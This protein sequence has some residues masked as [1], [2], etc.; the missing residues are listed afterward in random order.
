MYEWSAGSCR[1]QVRFF[2]A[3]SSLPL[4]TN[5]RGVSI[6]KDIIMI[7]RLIGT[8]LRK[9]RILVVERR[10]DKAY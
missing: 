7:I 4:S 8:N 5:H 10:N 3:C 9:V 1:N 2:K 6:I